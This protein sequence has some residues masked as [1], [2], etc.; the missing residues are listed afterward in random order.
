MDQLD[1]FADPRPA[2]PDDPPWGY[3]DRFGLLRPRPPEDF[4][5]FKHPRQAGQ[6]CP[7]CGQ[8]F[9]AVYGSPPTR[10]Q[11]PRYADPTAQALADERHR[12]GQMPPE[13]RTWSEYL[14]PYQGE[15]LLHHWSRYGVGVTSCCQ[16]D[17]WNDWVQA[18]VPAHSPRKGGYLRYI[19][20]ASYARQKRQQTF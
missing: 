6:P 2:L 16:A 17:L 4:H 19:P 10:R 20:T 13:E 9:G 5:P 11:A 1:L 3:R 15:P 8:P 14:L 18:H 12:Q 7:L